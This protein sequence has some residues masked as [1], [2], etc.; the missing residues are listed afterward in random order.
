M[1]NLLTVHPPTT[2]AEGESQPVVINWNIMNAFRDNDTGCDI[3]MRWLKI[4]KELIRM[5]TARVQVIALQEMGRCKFLDD[6][7][8][9]H[10]TKAGYKVI[11]C[12]FNESANSFAIFVAIREDDVMRV[13]DVVPVPL[14]GK[15]EHGGRTIWPRT[16]PVVRC[17]QGDEDITFI[18]VHPE[19]HEGTRVDSFDKVIIPLIKEEMSEGRNVVL[20]GDLNL[21][22]DCASSER[23]IEE[24][25]GLLPD[26]NKGAASWVGTPRD[27]P[28]ER[29]GEITKQLD[30]VFTNRQITAWFT[31]WPNNGKQLTGIMPNGVMDPKW[32]PDVYAMASDH[33]PVGVVFASPQG[34]GGNILAELECSGLVFN[35]SQITRV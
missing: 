12:K 11:V 19:V 1:D 21:F 15:Y 17:V 29:Y 6:A 34:G 28:V 16:I 33:L 5:I 30:W 3:M 4:M 25:H 10:L 9:A 35:R 26:S 2:P 32:N 13:A 18:V 27:F 20:L 31:L 24:L 8:I 14:N 23:I 22:P 7:V